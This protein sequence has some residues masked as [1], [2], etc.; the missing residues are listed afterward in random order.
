MLLI[1]PLLLF[2]ALIHGQKERVFF[3]GDLI[4]I[5]KQS[6]LEWLGRQGAFKSRALWS[7]R[8][9]KGLI[10]YWHKHEYCIK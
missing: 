9:G 1:N 10:S 2:K 4:Y 3:S 7:V 5:Q 6:T 8:A